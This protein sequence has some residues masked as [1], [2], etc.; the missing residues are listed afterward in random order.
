MTARETDYDAFRSQVVVAKEQDD[1]AAIVSWA[2]VVA[3]PLRQPVQLAG[4]PVN[5]GEVADQPRA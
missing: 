5:H 2:G 1:L 4:Q 3:V